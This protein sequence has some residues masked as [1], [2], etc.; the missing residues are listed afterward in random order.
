MNIK[1]AVLA[2]C[3]T[4]ICFSFSG[5]GNTE[6]IEVGKILS[7]YTAVY[8]ITAANGIEYDNSYTVESD[9][10]E[11]TVSSI[12]ETPYII[13]DTATGNETN[14]GEQTITT[15]SRLLNTEKDGC[16]RGVPVY[17]EEEF[18][19]TGDKTQYVG[20][21]FEH[22]HK[23]NAGTLKTKKY[24]KSDEG[25]IK[26]TLYTVSLSK[27]YFDKDSLP[28]IIGAFSQD[29]GVISISS[30]NRD[31]LQTVKYEYMGNETVET[32]LGNID[33]KKIII[34][35]NTAFTS[36]SAAIFVDASGFPVKVEHDSSIMLISSFSK[37]ENSN[38]E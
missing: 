37:T 22:D 4:A 27:Q 9:E 2:L 29:S 23:L 10:N 35:P 17:I 14:A 34:R 13:T 31:R 21:S 11:F 24:S 15:V 19:N 36:N 8:H 28:F 38:I 30:G 32:P 12:A 16:S 1:K 25:E 33:C 6:K 18:I 5:C 3:L 7:G 20:F 26:E